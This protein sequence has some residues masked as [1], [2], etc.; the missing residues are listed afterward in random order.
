MAGDW[1]KMRVGLHTHPKIVRIASAS[2]ADRLRVIGAL[3]SAWCLFDAHSIDGK[4]EGYSLATLDELIGF[5]GFGLA[6]QSVGWLLEDGGS[7]VM[8]SFSTHNGQSAKRRAQDS[9]RKREVRKQSAPDVDKV[10]TREEKRRVNTPLPPATGGGVDNSAGAAN[11]GTATD[12]DPV[13]AK[14]ERDE[15]NTAPMPQ[16]VR[17]L[18]AR[19]KVQERHG[20]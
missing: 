3:H 20:T 15:R 14:L 7:L 12:R 18:A 9:E 4:L 17:D 13:L 16:S 8:P 6:M 10:R 11:T 1:I 19:L 5:T 2:N